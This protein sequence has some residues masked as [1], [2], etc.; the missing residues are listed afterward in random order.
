MQI[1][2]TDGSVP[3][4]RTQA[5][6]H[7]PEIIPQASLDLLSLYIFHIDRIFLFN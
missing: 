1:H 4:L 6:S 5:T 3:K 7:D 2:E